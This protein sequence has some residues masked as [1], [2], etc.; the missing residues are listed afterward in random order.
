MVKD[1][2]DREGYRFF[3]FIFTLFMLIGIINLFG[4]IPYTFTPTTHIVL[5]FGLSLS[6]FIGCVGLGF[7]NHKIEYFSYVRAMHVSHATTLAAPLEPTPGV[8]GPP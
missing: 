3:P 1:N 2:M 7:Y 5:T 8:A 6:I 4:L